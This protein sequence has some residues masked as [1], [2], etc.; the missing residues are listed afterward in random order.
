MGFLDALLQGFAVALTPTN[1]M[2]ALFGCFAG[3]IIGALPG[4]GP[5]NGVAILIPLAFSLGLEPTSALIMLS[6]IYYGCMYGGRISSI[7][8][9]IPGDE[10]AIMTT[11]DGYPMAQAGKASEA[12]GISAVASFVGA[13]FATLGLTLFAPLLAK[14]AIHFGPADYFALYVLAFA[15]IGG[16]T[17]VNPFKTLLAAFLGLMVASVGLDPATGTPRYTFGSY[18]LYDG[19]DPIVA[20]VGLFA[21]SEVLVYLERLNFS[22]ARM[23]PLGR[24]LPRIKDLLS[25]GWANLRGSVI[26]FVCGI[27]PGAGASLGAFMSYIFEQRWSA[28]DGNFGKGDPRGIAAPEAGNNAA[29]GGALIPMLTLGVP[30]SGTT[31]VMLALL[32]SLNIQPGPL[33]FDRQPDLVWGL[34]AA[35]YIANIVLLVMNIPMIGLFTRMLA[36]P[37][38]ILMPFVVMVSFLGVYSISHSTFDLFVMVAFG[39]IG[40]ILRLIGISLV[41]IILGLLLGADMEN[42]LRRALSISNGDF[43]FLFQSPI[44]LGLYAVT[45]TMLT[46][47]LVL[48]LRRDKDVQAQG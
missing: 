47:A 40:Y 11:L 10:P 12:L 29:S 14:A 9:N 32:I 20:I 39:V 27:L 16:I 34:I 35:L 33:L 18:H 17:S 48:S 7:M 4:L 38:W 2:L 45:G 23:V 6:C 28:R 3:T 43:T 22:E 15:T 13:T 19:F 5:V 46:I 8:L 26:G 30:G 37:Q 44:A 36:M 42:N 31:A 24:A 25:G 21:I 1:L 41:P